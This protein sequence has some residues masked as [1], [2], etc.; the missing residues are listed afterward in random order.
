MTP[1]G[2]I[3]AELHHLFGHEVGLSDWICVDQNKIDTFAA[4]TNDDSWMHTDPERTARQSPF[5]TTIAQSFLVLSHLTD[6]VGAVDIPIPGIVYRQNY[7]FDRLRILQPVEEGQRIRGR[8]ELNRIDPKGRLGLLLHFDVSIE[9]EDD[10][11][12]PAL[13][14]EWLAYVRVE[15]KPVE[16]K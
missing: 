3:I 15:E 4:C 14:A 2:R 16:E 13:V 5:G 7:G 8:F 12:I 6:M 11:D 10:Q 9:I 1:A